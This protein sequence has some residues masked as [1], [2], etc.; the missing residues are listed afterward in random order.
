MAAQ[1]DA[2]YRVPLLDRHVEN[3]A[4]AQDAGDVHQDIQFAVFL[5]RLI[6]E[7]LAAFGSRDVLW[8]E[9]AAPSAALISLATS[10]AGE[11]VSFC[12]ATANS[13]VVDHDR[14]TLGGQRL[15]DFATDSTSATGYGGN[16]TFEMTSH[17]LRSPLRRRAALQ[18]ESL[19][20][21]S[22]L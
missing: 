1:M 11:W 20:V 6:D 18:I 2:D 13:Q 10:S 5:D 8:F 3:H 16:F 22:S 14:G 21:L 17:R 7:A 15:G 9:E 4:V 12:P 19:C